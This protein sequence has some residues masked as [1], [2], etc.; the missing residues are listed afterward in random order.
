M[1]SG[2]QVASD[3]ADERGVLIC[4]GSGGLTPARL[5]EMVDRRYAQH[6]EEWGFVAAGVLAGAVIETCKTQINEERR[7]A[8]LPALD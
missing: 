3:K 2:S 5:A 7:R 4:A 1:N 6:S 8:G